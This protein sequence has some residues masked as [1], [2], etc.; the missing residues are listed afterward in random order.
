MSMQFAQ[1][2]NN[3]IENV[4]ALNDLSLLPLFSIGYDLVI[5]IDELNPVPGIG[6]S[7][8]GM[9]FTAPPPPEP[10]G[11][12]IP[13]MTTDDRDSITAEGT[14]IYNSDSKVLEFFDGD[15]WHE[16]A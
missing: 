8:D 13:I 1:I 3:L 10:M 2:K 14:L 16:L 4:I 5:R 7:Y 15:V 11:K 9:D 12:K 6:W